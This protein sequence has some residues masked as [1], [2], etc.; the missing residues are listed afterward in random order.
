MIGFEAPFE[1]ELNSLLSGAI[2]VGLFLLAARILYIFIRR[3]FE[4]RLDRA[5]LKGL[6]AIYKYSVITVLLV[7]T[8]AVFNNVFRNVLASV[9][10]FAA[11]L[12]IALQRPILN[13]FGWLTIVLKKTYA[14]GDRIS[15]GSSKG[16]VFEINMMYTSM[17]EL[18]DDAPSGRM[19]SVPNEF[20]LTQP[21]SNYTKGTPYVWDTLSIILE[22]DSDVELAKSLL[23]KAASE[24]VGRLMDELS[25]KW[26]AS[27]GRA[28]TVEPETGVEI[29][30]VNG[31]SAIQVSVRYLCN[32]R[33]KKSVRSR[34]YNLLLARIRKSR[35]VKLK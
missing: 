2:A 14:I 18:Q 33:E 4:Q 35:G 13:I 30:V 20:V 6:I 26:S 1:F 8:V 19:I 32:V 17:S 15:I 22:K 27:D 34:I 28:V 21:V 24:V 3:H 10:L 31:A 11:G 12:T 9:G 7:I 29:V 25:E 5:Q 16:D 23:E